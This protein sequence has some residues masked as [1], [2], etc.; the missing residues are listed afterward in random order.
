[1]QAGLNAMA[2]LRVTVVAGKGLRKPAVGKRAGAGPA[3]ETAA[4]MAALAPVCV[5]ELAGMQGRAGFAAQPPA[6]ASTPKGFVVWQQ[7]FVFAF[8]TLG[9]K[10]AAAAA[11][12]GG[13]P[14]APPTM[15]VT[16]LGRPGRLRRLSSTL[17]GGEGVGA[18]DLVPVGTAELPMAEVRAN[19]SYSRI[20]IRR[21]SSNGATDEPGLVGCRRHR[22]VYAAAEAGGNGV[23]SNSVIERACALLSPTLAH[24]GNVRLRFQYSRTDGAAPLV[25]DAAQVRASE[26]KAAKKYAACVLDLLARRGVGS[27]VGQVHAST[28]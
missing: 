6:G 28:R 11:G 5:V 1:M 26:A 12:G 24:A 10:K 8:P 13:D 18:A 4:A 16:V 9:S 3:V 25:L 7:N 14:L 27:D 17:G 15:A 23:E 20:D 2:E 21:I 22:Q 19:D